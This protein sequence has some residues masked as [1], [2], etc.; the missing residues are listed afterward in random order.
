VRGLAVVLAAALV[1]VA[2]PT[3]SSAGIDTIGSS[4]SGSATSVIQPLQDTALT[5]LTAAGGGRPAVPN[6]GQVL[7]VKV[8][9]CAAR[10]GRHVRPETAIFTQDLRGEPDGALRVI[11]SSQRFNL[12]ICG[13]HGASRRSVRRFK[14]RDQCVAAGDLVG[15]VVGGQTPGYP[16]GTPYFIA[17]PNPGL[18]VG[19]F[20]GNGA[21]LNGSRY[22]FAPMADTELLARAK[23]GT[24]PDSPSRC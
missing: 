1:L 24:G 11:S 21:T 8:K 10:R 2:V 3:T 6:S 16:Q 22:T 19:T 12:P 17:K 4:L 9:G 18:S 15:L 23:I 20:S 13:V 7:W 5:Q 14:P